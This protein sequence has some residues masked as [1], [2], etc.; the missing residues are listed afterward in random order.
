M[1]TQPNQSWDAHLYDSKHS[2][3]TT[4]GEDVLTLLNPQP[5]ERILDLGCG[6][7]HLTQQIAAK[8]A[9]VVGLDRSAEML[10]TARAA[11]PTI[12]FT[13]AD[14]ADFTTDTSF[15]AVFSNA[16]LHW[17]VEPQKPIASVWNALKPGG[18][19]VAE[20]GGKTNVEALIDAVYAATTA[21]ALTVPAPQWYFPSTAEYAELLEY[22]GFRVIYII[23]FDRPTPLEGSDA[24]PN[25]LRMYLP[26]VVDAVPV[27]D[28][29]RFFAAVE[30]GLRPKLYRDGTWYMD[31]VRLRFV[32]I[33]PGE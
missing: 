26:Q 16:A 6:T 32:A 2:F 15:D 24:I 27:P 17:M 33:K 23:H 28:R 11:Y 19:F 20:M 25:Y 1:T 29:D 3:V 13:E 14:A 21:L 7:G 18:R 31:Y 12:T 22:Q 5:G 9:Q 30:D 10:A 8:G 4:Y